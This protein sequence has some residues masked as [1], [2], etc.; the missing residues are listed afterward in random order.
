MNWILISNVTAG[1]GRFS[2]K[3]SNNIFLA[4]GRTYLSTDAGNSWNEVLE[5][6]DKGITDIHLI[7]KN[8]R[9]A[10]GSIGLVIK[11]Y[12][13]IIPVE[14]G[15]F[16]AT[17]K[18]DHEITLQW[19]TQTELNNLGFYVQR[20][21]NN[22][23]NI[24]KNWE[25]LGFIQGK[26]TTVGTNNYIFKD[27]VLSAC[28]Y[29]YRFKQIDFDGTTSYSDVIEI[30]ILSPSE[31]KLKQNYPNPFNA[32]TK[33]AFQLPEISIV[34]LTVYNVLGES[35]I[36]LVNKKLD[37][38]YYEYEFN[39]AQYSSGTYIYILQTENYMLSRKM[40]LLK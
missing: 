40:I 10:V 11:Y 9:Y 33:I 8:K 32:V 26:G 5:I 18:N 37:T 15:Y 20:S 34:K 17:I 24:E 14:L 29:Y 27:E 23:T 3:D 38:G 19:S 1:L 35:L 31:C 4:G 7:N 30:N 36:E 2:N 22:E 13:E 12:D 25:T 21:V 28:K 39:G 6:R 16:F